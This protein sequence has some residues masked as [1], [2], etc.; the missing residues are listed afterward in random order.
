MTNNA[1]DTPTPVPSPYVPPLMLWAG[2]GLKRDEYNLVCYP[3]R[4]LYPRTC[5]DEAQPES[6]T[7]KHDSK[8][9]S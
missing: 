8:E 2:A 4:G 3:P 6:S 5:T 9:R 1:D 7:Q